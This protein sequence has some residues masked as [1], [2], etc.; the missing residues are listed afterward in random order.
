MGAPQIEPLQV[1]NAVIKRLEE[2]R[3]ELG[4]FP[5]ATV[6][7]SNLHYLGRVLRPRHLPTTSREKD[8][9]KMT[10]D[11]L[12]KHAPALAEYLSLCSLLLDAGLEQEKK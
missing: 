4:P 5:N 2:L 11:G 8:I 12:T 1:K 9:A 6:M 7:A 3:L 10:Y